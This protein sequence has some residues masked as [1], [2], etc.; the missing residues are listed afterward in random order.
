MVQLLHLECFAKKHLDVFVDPLA[1]WQILQEKHCVLVVHLFQLRCKLQEQGSADIAV[2]LTEALFF[3]KV[4]VPQ[5]GDLVY[6]ELSCQ[7]TGHPSVGKVHED[8]VHRLQMLKTGA[9]KLLN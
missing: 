6:I 8:D 7:V 2:K 9:V 5:S 3:C 1:S 4:S